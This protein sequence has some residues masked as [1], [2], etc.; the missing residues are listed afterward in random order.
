MLEHA[1]VVCNTRVELTEHC[2]IRLVRFY[3]ESADRIPA[4]PYLGVFKLSCFLCSSFLKHLQDGDLPGKRIGFG[5]RGDHGK[6]YGRWLAPDYIR[7]TGDTRDRVLGAL[8]LV[9]NDVK[10]RVRQ[11]LEAYSAQ[12]PLGGRFLRVVVG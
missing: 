5:V 6:F 4:I 7:C 10:D 2:E 1:L 9:T 8:Q 3:I 11:R 12:S